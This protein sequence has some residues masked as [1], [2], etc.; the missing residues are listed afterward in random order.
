MVTLGSYPRQG[1]SRAEVSHQ[2]GYA[3]GTPLPTEGE[4]HT[5]F[6]LIRRSTDQLVKLYFTSNGPVPEL[7]GQEEE[8][9]SPDNQSKMKRSCE[10]DGSGLF[11]PNAGQHFRDEQRR[12][13]SQYD[14][15]T[16]LAALEEYDYETTVHHFYS[17]PGQ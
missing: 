16:R 14:R 10:N 12:R 11:T 7:A 2:L 13:R 4:N 9:P 5:A 15:G 6:G 17:P 3:R 8:F 1:L